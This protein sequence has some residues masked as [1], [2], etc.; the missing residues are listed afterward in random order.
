MTNVPNVDQN[1]VNIM[2]FPRFVGATYNGLLSDWLV[3]WS[4]NGA[5]LRVTYFDLGDGFSTEWHTYQLTTTFEQEAS[6]IDMVRNNQQ[7][8]NL[9]NRC[10]SYG[11]CDYLVNLLGMFLVHE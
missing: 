1:S 7:R 3:L 10:L 4:L 6:D 8:T 9:S 5:H 2:P 11:S